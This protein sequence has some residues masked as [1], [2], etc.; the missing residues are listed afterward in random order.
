MHSKW[1]HIP[2]HAKSIKTKDAKCQNNNHESVPFAAISMCWKSF[3]KSDNACTEFLFS[4]FYFFFL[5][6]YRM[7]WNLISDMYSLR[8]QFMSREREKKE[9][10]LPKL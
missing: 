6:E 10:Y 1:C 7:T 5:V 9:I 2:L 8:S 4:C 3:A